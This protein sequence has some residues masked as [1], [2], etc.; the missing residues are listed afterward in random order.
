M[1][2][3]KK[4]RKCWR[5]AK[6]FVSKPS[7]LM[8]SDLQKVSHNAEQWWDY[9]ISF[10]IFNASFGIQNVPSTRTRRQSK[11]TFRPVGGAQDMNMKL[12]LYVD[13]VVIYVDVSGSVCTIS[14][15]LCTHKWLH[16]SGSL[17]RR[18]WFSM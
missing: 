11:T 5:Q 15:S 6:H 10:V 12:V 8:F 2:T 18:K 1:K 17:C 13:D 9:P 14:C 4:R 7:S 16:I 3:V